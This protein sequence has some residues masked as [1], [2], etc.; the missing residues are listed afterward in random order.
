MAKHEAQETTDAVDSAAP[1]PPRDNASSSRVDVDSGK[2]KDAEHSPAFARRSGAGGGG[3]GG[4]RTTAPPDATVGVSL[5][6]LADDRSGG[7]GG[8]DSEG[9][10]V[11]IDDV[12][13]KDWLP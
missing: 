10:E 3:A 4:G 1:P 11:S 13:H 7:S 5:A 8:G 2:Q 9:L 6:P 12:S